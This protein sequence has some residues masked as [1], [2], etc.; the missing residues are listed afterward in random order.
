MTDTPVS[1]EQWLQQELSFI[2]TTMAHTLNGQLKAAL[3][4]AMTSLSP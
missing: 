2:N 1:T 4:P 3:W